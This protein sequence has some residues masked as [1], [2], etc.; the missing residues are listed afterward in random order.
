MQC[1]FSL[2][3][4]FLEPNISGRKNS[5]TFPSSKQRNRTSKHPFPYLPLRS[6]YCTCTSLASIHR[7]YFKF[8]SQVSSRKQLTKLLWPLNPPQYHRTITTERQRGLYGAVMLWVSPYASNLYAFATNNPRTYLTTT[9]SFPKLR[10]IHK[11]HIAA[12]KTT[13]PTDAPVLIAP[14]LCH[15]HFAF[16]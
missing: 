6:I 9:S 11:H 7:Q 8:P 5:E 14:S 10:Q 16:S 2:L 15:C 4:K 1:P 13:H 3:S 12:A